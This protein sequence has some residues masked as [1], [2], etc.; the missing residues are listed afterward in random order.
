MNKDLTL[1]LVRR[2]PVLYQDFYSSPQNS[3]MCW[4]FDHGDGWFDLIWQLSLAIEDELNYSQNQKNWFLFKKRWA[5]RWNDLIYK[6]SPVQHA[7]YEM[8]GK[9]TKEDP[10]RR[11]MVE[12]AKIN[13]IDVIVREILT[14]IA[15]WKKNRDIHFGSGLKFF[16]WYPY[17]GFAVSQVK[18]KFGGLRYYLA[19]GGGD[20]IY[21]FITLAER[22]SEC[23]CEV[24]GKHG[25]LVGTNWVSTLCKE[26]AKGEGTPDPVY[27]QKEGLDANPGTV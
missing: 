23:T 20:H 1:K 8:Q 6:L 26:H 3:S 11:V 12:P 22:L 15:P 19:R 25:A 9:G 14:A 27:S 24:C 21:S 10:L 5:T 2:F 13:T 7:K 16:V 4:G 17:T 18:E